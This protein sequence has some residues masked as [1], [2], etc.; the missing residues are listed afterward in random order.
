MDVFEFDAR[1]IQLDT[2]SDIDEEGV[3][4]EC[5]DIT[6]GTGEGWLFSIVERPMGLFLRA[7]MSEIP[8]ALLV[9]V[10]KIVEPRQG[11]H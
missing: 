1:L 4:T 10:L 6:A 9:H 11:G 8:I 7:G 2:S 3:V 5:W